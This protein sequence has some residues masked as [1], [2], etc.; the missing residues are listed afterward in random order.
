MSRGP[1]HANATVVG[2]RTYVLGGL[3]EASVGQR[4]WRSVADSWV[5]K[6]SIAS[7]KTLPEVPTGEERGS[8]A[9]GVYREKI[10]LAA[11]MTE[12]ELFPSGIQRNVSVVSVFDT[13]KR[14]WVFIPDAAKYVPEAR[15]HAGTT[16]V[17]LKMYVLGGRRD[18]QE[19]ARDTVFL[20]DLRGL[21]NERK[22][23]SARIPT[24][25]GGVAAGVLRERVYVLGGE[26]NV[27][28]D[29]GS[30][31]QVQAY[32]TRNQSWESARNIR[33]PRHGTTAVGVDGKLY[34]PG[35][36]SQ[37]GAPVAVFDAFEL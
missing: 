4:A 37:S 23:T 1:N 35:G 32:D 33:V 18:G 36:V 21:E 8:T 20:R 29:Y 24:R 14:T 15:D 2:G 16:V 34:V 25:R 7:W 26:G 28:V 11:G 9:G 6:A 3:A 17:G 10:Y 27:Q 30:F 12:L 19:N 22:I 31:D 13:K 5:Y